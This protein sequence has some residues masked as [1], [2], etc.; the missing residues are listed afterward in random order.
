MAGKQ[1]MQYRGVVSVHSRDCGRGHSVPVDVMRGGTDD[2]RR[3]YCV[4]AIAGGMVKGS[5]SAGVFCIWISAGFNE[6]G[7][8]CCVAVAGGVM[9]WSAALCISRGKTCG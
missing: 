3:N 7:D 6:N 4:V 2:K 1:E 5:P 8:C 9:K